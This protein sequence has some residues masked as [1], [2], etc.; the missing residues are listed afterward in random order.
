MYMSQYYDEQRF[1]AWKLP[2]PLIIHWVLNPALAFNEL[3]LGQRLPV[4]TLID[5]TSDASL[6][7][8]SYVPCPHC[9]TLNDARIWGYGNA[10]GHW[11]GYVCPEC[12]ARIPCLWNVSSLAVLL[13]TFPVWILL[14]RF[15]RDRW[16]ARSLVRARAARQ[17][18]LATESKVNHPYVRAG[19]LF[20]VLMFCIMAL[21]PY[22]AGKSTLQQLAV[23]AVI[24][25]SSGAAFGFLMW[26]FTGRRRN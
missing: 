5:K 18:L 15:G 21:L 8:R 14:W 24:W 17:R 3:V 4:L 26:F 20:G 2:H 11:F 19:L 6:A 7:E 13:V 16:L 23:G 12:G 9:S 25:M 1:K 10:F 22:I